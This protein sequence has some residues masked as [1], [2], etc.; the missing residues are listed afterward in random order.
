LTDYNF[1][2][3]LM[4]TFAMLVAG[5]TEVGWKKIEMSR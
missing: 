2:E 5:I 3:F 1:S 4:E